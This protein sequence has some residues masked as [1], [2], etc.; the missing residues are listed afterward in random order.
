MDLLCITC[1]YGY[2]NNAGT[3][4]DQVNNL[5]TNCVKN[6]DTICT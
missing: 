1:N 4:C 5:P 6:N 2:N 3:S